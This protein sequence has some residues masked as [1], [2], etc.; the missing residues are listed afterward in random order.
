MQDFTT[1]NPSQGSSQSLALTSEAVFFQKVYMWMC[2]GL[3]LTALVGYWLARSETW[4]S[5]LSGGGW[6]WL[7]P[8][9]IQV[10]LVLAI[11][12]LSNKV[13]ATV[14]KGLFLLYATS[15]GMTVSI[16]LMVYPMDIVF[17]AFLSA[18]AVYGA[19]ATYGLVTKRSLEAWG[20]FLFMG[21]VGTI[22]AIVINM[23]L[24]SPMMDFIISCVTVIVFAGL[25]A[26]DH[27][28]LRVIHA[29]GF[30]S[31]DYEGKIIIHG[32]LELYLDFINL[33][34]ALVRILGNRD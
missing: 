32:A 8:I 29:N 23:I 17:K 21:L 22:I 10:G 18:A 1:P 3:A 2:G 13:T 33:F 19:M 12:Y 14:I 16:V 27:Q 31:E 6:A 20:G 25:T 4:A 9:V 11:N 34:L 24:R 5:Y 15:V 7:L 30:S 26:Y 28:K